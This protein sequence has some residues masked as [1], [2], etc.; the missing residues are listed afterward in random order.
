MGGL[1]PAAPPVGEAMITGEPL[2]AV[3]DAGDE[4]IGGT[5]VES[6]YLE[7]EVTKTGEDAFLARMLSLVE[8]AQGIQIP[9]QA[10]ADRVSGI[11]VPAVFSLA[12]LTFGRLG[13]CSTRASFPY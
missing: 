13:Y 3:K 8:Q 2:P 1:L 11:F 5:V 7:V 6:G 4:V 9:L 10:L 12:I